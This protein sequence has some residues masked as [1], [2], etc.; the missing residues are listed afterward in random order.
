MIPIGTDGV[1]SEG[2][3]AHCSKAGHG[4]LEPLTL[5]TSFGG[6]EV[7]GV[8]HSSQLWNPYPSSTTTEHTL[9]VFAMAST[10]VSLPCSRFRYAELLLWKKRKRWR[11]NVVVEQEKTSREMESRREEVATYEK[12]GL[13]RASFR[14]GTSLTRAASQRM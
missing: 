9:C 11:E 5:T 6:G 3:G 7:V 2:C 1:G 12:A 13:S 14:I 10:A 4:G 8:L